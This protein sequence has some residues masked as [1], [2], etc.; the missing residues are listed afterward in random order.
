MGWCNSF[1]SKIFQSIAKL[2][3]PHT[4]Q[5]DHMLSLTVLSFTKIIHQLCKNLHIVYK[6]YHTYITYEK[7]E[8][9]FVSIE[10]WNNCGSRKHH[11]CV[12]GRFPLHHKNNAALYSIICSSLFTVVIDFAID[13]CKSVLFTLRNR[14]FLENTASY[15]VVSSCRKLRLASSIAQLAQICQIHI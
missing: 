2:T 8:H 12:P 7:S 5:N 3:S 14:Q 13:V 6:S 9:F 15:Y 11:F 1:D 4:V 10:F